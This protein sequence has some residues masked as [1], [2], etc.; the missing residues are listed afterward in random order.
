MGDPSAY[1][2]GGA[3]NT[4]SSQGNAPRWL[5]GAPRRSSVTRLLDWLIPGV[6][7]LCGDGA[8]RVPNLCRACLA[9]LPWLTDACRR[10]AAPCSSGG[11]CGRCLTE[12]PPFDAVRAV[13]RYEGTARVLIR[14]VKYHADL[15]AAHTLGWILAE[16][17]ALT[18]GEE[19]QPEAIVPVPL[20][21]ERLRERGFN[22]ALELARPAAVRLGLPLLPRACRRVRATPPQAEQRSA[23]ARRASPRGAFAAGQ[24]VT[25]FGCVA[26]VD[27]VLTTGATVAAATR[28]LRVAG[29]GRVE[30]W[31]L[32]RVPGHPGGQS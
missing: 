1:Q 11:L 16:H 27:D 18:S 7:L 31:V 5:A 22:Q 28:A 14:A 29:A 8:G 30:V 9:D 13:L 21:R 6:C 10:C 32:A 19:D 4:S 24:Q 26:L 25:G 17:L 3:D 23:A 2:A 15:A 20:H 12:P